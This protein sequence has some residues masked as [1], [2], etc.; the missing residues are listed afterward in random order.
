MPRRQRINP[1]DLAQNLRKRLKLVNIPVPVERIAKALGAEVRFSPLDDE[2]SG[3]IFVKAGIPVIGVNALHHPNRQR[4]TIAHEIG[5]LEMHR[6]LIEA[7]VHVDKAFS[8]FTG[9]R[10]D[11]NSSIGNDTIEIEAN[12]FAAELLIPEQE[13]IDMVGKQVIDIDD[14][15]PVEELARRF[16]VSRKAMEYRLLRVANRN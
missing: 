7:K 8:T 2:L 10:R 16:K 12:Q 6:N 1:E 5:H 11:G 4:F 15:G 3:M 13:L 9:L 14:D